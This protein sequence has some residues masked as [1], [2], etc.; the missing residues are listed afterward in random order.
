MNRGGLE[1]RLMD[2]IR[3]LDFQRVQMDIFT[4]R[5]EPGLMDE[6]AEAYGCKIYYNK[7]L[8]IR[9]MFQYVEYFADFLRKHPEYQIIHAHQDA[10]CSVFCKGAKLAG[11]P[12]RI[13]HSRT[14]IS[15]FNIKNMLKNII[16]L[17]VGKY[18]THFF[19]VSDLAGEWLFGK[20]NVKKGKVE[21]WHNAIEAKKYQ[22]DAEKRNEKRQELGVT[23]KYVVLHVGN[24]TPPKNHERIIKIFR[25]IYRKRKDAVLLLVGK[26]ENPNIRTIVE[27]LEIKN[28]VRFLGTRTD[29]NELLFAGDIFLFPSIFEGMPGAVIEA[30]T[31]GLPCV[32]SDSITKEV[33]ITNHIVQVPLSV[34][35]EVWA[36]Q[37]L[38]MQEPDRIAAYEEI[39]KAGYDIDVL[40]KKLTKFYETAL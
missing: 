34:S 16:K 35:D 7:P 5:L 40:V 37:V 23:D 4:Y 6:E 29:I 28:A 25:E 22:Y 30:Q 12:I 14:A 20:R 10:W 8:T 15:S 13:A 21:I 26:E 1:S 32:I 11:V 9:N 17:P 38:R 33:C 18:A 2:I 19:A 27:Q 24:F 39:R 31:A 3:N 36:E